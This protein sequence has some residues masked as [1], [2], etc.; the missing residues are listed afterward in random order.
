MIILSKKKRILHNSV[1]SLLSNIVTKFAN[2]IVFILVARQAGPF[3]AGVF[4]LGT[5]CLAIIL[6]LS[7]G[8]DEILIRSIAR[9]PSDT[10]RQVSYISVTRII[11]SLFMYIVLS[12]ILIYH[13]DFAQFTTN[14]IIF[15]CISVIPEN[16]AN[17]AQSTLI[18]HEN[19]G[20]IFLAGILSSITKIAGAFFSLLNGGGLNGV[21]WTWLAGSVIGAF[22]QWWG[23]FRIRTLSKPTTWVTKEFFF[24]N[25][26]SLIP[27]LW[28]GL[29][30]A[31]EFQADVVILSI[32]RNEKEVSLYTAPITILFALL[33]IAQAIRNGIYPAFVQNHLSDNTKLFRL[34]E[35]TFQF[36]GALAFPMAF[37]LSLLSKSIITNI[38]SSNFLGAIIPLRIVAWSL[39]FY[40]LNVPNIRIMLV[41]DKQS[42]ISIFQAISLTANLL[43]NFLLDSRLGAVG[44]AIA[45]LVSSLI[46]FFLCFIFVKSHIRSQNPTRR[47]IK[48]LFASL[49]MAV[50]I[51]ALRNINIWVL[52]TIAIVIYSST[53]LLIGGIN[54]D[55]RI[56][57]QQQL[58]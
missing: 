17:S 16:F 27:F 25:Y 2:A 14:I 31:L 29:F 33:L 32:V 34:Y 56:W 19:F 26:K 12:V 22:I 48:P 9:N 38:Y 57:I 43:L 28:I 44:A 6:A 39:V 50:V 49:I 36:L 7:L 11:V 37:G 45:R 51:F 55:D 13:S 20:Y 15:L 58:T 53:Y 8:F 24:S 10:W 41:F 54:R 1:I 35:L 47:I 18:A 3:Q 4:S 30:F 42:W 5:S 21:V 46:F 40:Y 52:I 23:I